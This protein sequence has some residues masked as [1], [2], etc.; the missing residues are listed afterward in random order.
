M[1]HKKKS[2]NIENAIAGIIITAEVFN[3]SIFSETWLVEKK[4]IPYDA[5]TGI[6]IFSPELVQ[7]NAL[8]TQVLIIP[9]QMQIT[10]PINDE[11]ANCDFQRK[12][13]AES[14]ELL[15]QTPYK[16]LG[17]NFDYFVSTPPEED[18]IE[19]NHNL[20]GGGSNKLLEEFATK[21]SKFGRYFSKNYGESR[22]KLDI[23]PVKA[24]P[25]QK[26]LIR[27]SFN[28]H[29]DAIQEDQSRRIKK[30]VEQIESWC[31]LRD[32][33][34]KLLENGSLL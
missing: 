13:A 15:P 25:G 6:R 32:Y 24:G 8:N 5:F 34:I 28:F 12:V 19:Y 2:P 27:F 26:D 11:N 22:L 3:P 7:F 33:A 4:I 17:I 18:F 14:I 16:A 1:P 30:L 10:F 21:D 20:L 29:H 9:Q 31:S 23:K